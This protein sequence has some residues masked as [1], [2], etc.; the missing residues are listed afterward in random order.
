MKRSIR[1]SFVSI[2]CCLVL[3]C[4]SEDDENP[5]PGNNNPPDLKTITIDPTVTFQEM[6][7][8]GGA[9]TW[10]SDRLITTASKNTIA[11]LLFEDMGTDIVR[12]QAFY[13]PDNYPDYKGTTNMSYDNSAMLFTRTGEI[14]DLMNGYEPDIKV[15]LSSWGPPASLKSNDSPREGTLKK[16]ADG[17]MYDE[18]AQY[19]EDILDNTPFNPDYISIQNEPGYSNPG[20]T[21][22]NWSGTETA[23]LP[24]YD[25]AFD[26]VY[27]KIKD[28][29]N[30]PVMIGPE[31][32]NTTSFSSFAEP[33]KNKD[34]LGMFAYHPYDFSSSVSPGLMN[35]QLQIIKGYNTKPNLMTE[36][37]DN[38]SWLNTAAFVNR[39]LTEAN[40][41]GYIYW[42]MIWATPA[43]GNDVA[44]V[45]I[46]SSGNYVVTPYYYL[47][48]HFAKDIDAGY[49][50]IEAISQVTALSISGFI[51]PS[52]DKL[53][54]VII[55]TGAQTKVG[56]DLKNKTIKDIEVKQSTERSLYKVVEGVNP[57]DEITFPAQSI[58]TIV[59]DI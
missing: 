50:R 6:V 40:S 55:N 3:S 13:Y 9:L 26:K 59:L 28:R 12:F 39:T 47:F 2:L 49:K 42:K 1:I 24:G 7:G 34:H 52:E 31:S 48:K 25:A 27:D 56:L 29:T 21:T 11:Q 17:F 45:S 51:N 22:C 54:L 44:M 32:P 58:T 57:G 53:T 8:F 46:N 18:F 4:G 5:Q 14:Y 43:S 15:L 19:W 41:S 37:S 38:L 23:T 33:L 16:D 30:R 10:Y 36:F 20:W 35:Q